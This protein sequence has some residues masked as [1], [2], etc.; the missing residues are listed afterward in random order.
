MLKFIDVYHGNPTSTVDAA[1][2]ASDGVIAKA[3]EGGGYVDPEHAATVAAARKAGKLVGHYHFGWF[4]Q[5]PATQAAHFVTAAG[6][7][8]G[9]VLALDVEREANA[10]VAQWPASAHDRLGFLLEFSRQVLH[11]TGAPCW[12][13]ANRSDWAA[14][15]AA[16]TPA[17]KAQLLAL[18]LWIADPSS[19]N[20]HPAIS[21]PWTMQQIGISAGI[22]RDVFNGT[23]AAFHA[24]GVPTVAAPAPKP[25]PVPPTPTPRPEPA[26][27]PV[28][29]LSELRWLRSSSSSLILSKALV[30]EHL[31]SVARS[32]WTIRGNGLALRHYRTLHG[33]GKDTAGAV[34]ALGKAHG[35][36]V[37]A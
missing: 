16:A 7:R 35:F 29:R 5:D 21:T 11:L 34:R 12:H 22:D 2:A 10:G 9:E 18:P 6:A 3:S 19:P 1:L 30:A 14:L 13:Y 36:D 23:A 37:E 24:L 17:Q 27:R 32:L 33:F 25:V 8:P 28:V 20:G 31:I 15:L 4:G 26:P